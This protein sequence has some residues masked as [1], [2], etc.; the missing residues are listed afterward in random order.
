M[1]PFARAF[2]RY[3]LF[4][5]LEGIKSDLLL[6]MDESKN[7]FYEATSIG[8]TGRRVAPMGYRSFQAF[9]R[10]AEEIWTECENLFTQIFAEGN[11]LKT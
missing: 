9:N 7:E 2:Q 6:F 10:R 11:P 8:R 1:G 5:R 3:I 4:E